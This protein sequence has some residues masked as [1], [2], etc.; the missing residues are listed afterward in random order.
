MK[1]NT[2][3]TRAGFSVVQ[4]LITVAVIGIVMAMAFVGITKARAHIRRS[5]S[6]HQFAMYV[7]RARADAVRRHATTTIQQV[8]T[9]TYTV[10]MDF[11]GS[12]TPTWQNFSTENGVTISMPRT[13]VFDWRGR[14]PTETNVQF[15]NELTGSSSVDITG[16]GDITIDSEI[17]H[18]GSIPA[19]T[20]LGS[21]GGA[22]PDPGPTPSA[23]PTPS[24]AP[25]PSASPSASPNPSA[26][27]SA[28][29][30][31]SASPTASPMPSASPT[32][33]PMPSASPSATASPGQCS[34]YG[35]DAIT[36]SQN[37]SGPI[38]IRLFNF[39]GSG[40]ITATSSNNG[41]LQV[42]PDSATV[43]G[44][45]PATFTVSVKKF[46]GSV[47]ISSPCGTKTVTVTVQ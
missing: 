16:S 28:L 38:T 2:H 5:N 42:S 11:S 46:N 35:P 25:S 19:V 8:N 30:T 14:T 31:P 13:V 41:Q 26:S 40:T 37:G 21:G 47:T 12:G 6:A 27:P 23:S 7:E 36:I 39:T 24:P 20:L 43:D 10:N 18:D 1:K 44:A 29:P 4:L 34:I 3:S 9:T 33:S 32:A 15:T 17:F 22:L 45:I